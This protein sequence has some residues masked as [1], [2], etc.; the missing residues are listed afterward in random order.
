M[1]KWQW[2][3]LK[4]YPIIYLERLGKP[5]KTSIWIVGSRPR[6]ELG[7]SHIQVRSII[8]KPNCSVP[9]DMQN[10]CEYIEYESVHNKLHMVLWLKG[11]AQGQ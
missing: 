3:N 4:Y 7:T 10:S 2:P 9:P 11:Y 8:V 1:W 6:F 5:I